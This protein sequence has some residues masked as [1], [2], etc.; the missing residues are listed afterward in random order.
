MSKDS[1]IVRFDWRHD[2]VSVG[3]IAIRVS[4]Q[5]KQVLRLMVE[6]A[7]RVCDREALMGVVWGARAAHMDELYLTQLVYRLRKSLRP[8]GLG[9]HIVTMPRAGYRF[10]PEGLRIH[11][12]D[13]PPDD[14]PMSVGALAADGPTPRGASFRSWFARM[15]DTASYQPT[16]PES[17]GLPAIHTEEGVVTHAGATVYLTGFECAL[18]EAF[19]EQPDVTLKRHELISRIWGD[20]EDVDVNRLTRLVS[21]LRRSLQPLGLEQ[22]L[23][24]IPCSGYRFCRTGSPS[25]TD[26]GGVGSGTLP[27]VA[28]ARQSLP[29]VVAA[30]TW[31]APLPA[32]RRAVVPI[33][34]ALF[35]LATALVMPADLGNASRFGRPVVA[36]RTG[37]GIPITCSPDFVHHLFIRDVVASLAASSS[38]TVPTTMDNAWRR[39][40]TDL[41][42]AGCLGVTSSEPS[43]PP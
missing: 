42:A 28:A 33:G 23:I 41:R 2:R 10:D 21:R 40:V 18:L 29:R 27:S 15:R 43:Y 16:L 35:A 12:D 39:I 11:A 9:D 7:G 32:S 30:L 19:V 24:Y 5:E 6:R 31:I 36:L 38:P 34:V 37:R 14:P 4:G 8:L 17:I 13:L 26:I 22:Q 20:E 1:C 25:P 3:H